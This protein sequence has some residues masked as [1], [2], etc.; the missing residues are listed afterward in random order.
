MT[1]QEQQLRA[2]VLLIAQVFLVLKVREHGGANKGEVV[3][4]FLR[5]QGGH[6][7]QPWC[8]AFAAWCLETAC[9]L[10]GIK[11]PIDAN[12]SSSDL[13][14]K[15]EKAG[16]IKQPGAARAGDLFVLKGGPTG[17]KH[18][19]L[20]AGKLLANGKLPTIEGNTNDAGSAEGDGVYKKERNI[21]TIVVIDTA[22]N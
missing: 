10:H 11:V 7:G 1:A 13:Y 18:T 3:E 2:A 6:G 15:A 20:V 22:P 4:A 9:K 16:R 19:G 21:A 14:R 8:V 12:L 5:S 17:F